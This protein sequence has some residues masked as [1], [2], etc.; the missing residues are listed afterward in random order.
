MKVV[1]VKTM[2]V[3]GTINQAE[4][5]AIRIGQPASI[6]FDAFPGLEMKG[7]VY[8]IGALATGGWRQNNY[9]RTIPIRVAIEGADQRVIPDLSASADVLLAR[10]E[11]KVVAPLAAIRNEN[12]KTLA[13]LKKDES[14][15]AREIKLGLQ[16]ENTAV[17]L[18]GLEVGEEVRL[19]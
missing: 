19:N 3:E 1:D 10:A 11:N 7:K 4:S 6:K 16:N 2:Q 17:V 8:S 5:G 15:E 13:Y 14:F 9:I 12:G 18:S